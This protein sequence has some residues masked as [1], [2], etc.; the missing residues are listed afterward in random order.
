SAGTLYFTGFESSEGYTTGPLA[1]QNG[2]VNSP[3]LV[4]ETGTVFAGTQ[5]V[6]LNATGALST[7]LANSPVSYNLG[8]NPVVLVDI[9]FQASATGTPSAWDVVSLFGDAGFIGQA[10]DVFGALELGLAS[11]LTGS[12]PLTRGI[13]NDVQMLLDFNTHT[14]SLYLNSS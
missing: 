2:W 14:Q 12:A 5:A 9:E 13:W 11:S 3:L 8:A 4:V 7:V 6:S 1:G 10:I